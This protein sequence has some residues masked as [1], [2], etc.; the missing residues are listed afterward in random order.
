MQLQVDIDWLNDLTGADIAGAFPLPRVFSAAHSMNSQ[1]TTHH[2][3]TCL[4]VCSASAQLPAYALAERHLRYLPTRV[5][6]GARYSRS[7]VRYQ[8]SQASGREGD[9]RPSDWMKVRLGEVLG[10]GQVLNLR[11][12]PTRG[13]R[14]PVLAYGSNGTN[15]VVGATRRRGPTTGTCL[16]SVVI[17]WLHALQAFT[18]SLF[19]LLGFGAERAIAVGTGDAI[20]VVGRWCCRAPVMLETPVLG[21]VGCEICHAQ[22]GR[23]ELMPCDAML[24]QGTE[25]GSFLCQLHLQA[26]CGWDLVPIML[27]AR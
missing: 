14:C 6:R 13:V 8:V 21:D 3:V 10:M 9:V 4:R 15:K 19:A 12:L 2:P 23:S 18:L 27:C 5:L 22:C 20:S 1:Q 24:L 26:G 17:S 25:T 16:W 11:Y 7:L